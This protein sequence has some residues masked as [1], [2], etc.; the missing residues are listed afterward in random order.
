MHNAAVSEPGSDAPASSTERLVFFTDAV[1]AI[2]ITL[3]VLPLLE[4]VT[5]DA[6]RQPDLGAL[7]HDHVRDFGAF[8]LSFAI[9]FRYWWAHHRIFWYIDAITPTL[10]RLSGLWIFGVA[11]LPLP[12]AI[13]ARYHTSSL[14]VG[15]YGANLVIVSAMTLLLALYAHRHKKPGPDTARATR[16]KVLSSV[17]AVVI[18]L[19]ATVVG[20]V[21]ARTVNYWAFLLMFLTGPVE[22]VVKARWRHAR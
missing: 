21:F 11:V 6:E 20:C 2:A 9:I 4:V 14:S 17:T 5:S 18:L 1:A 16:D 13:T 8:V 22:A 7:L 3:L 10:V 12:T 19:A 15:L